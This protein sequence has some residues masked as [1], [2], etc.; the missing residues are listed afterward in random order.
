[1]P[2]PNGSSFGIGFRSTEEAKLGLGFLL[3]VFCGLALWLDL[4]V[5]I[6]FIV[7]TLF[8]SGHEGTHHIRKDVQSR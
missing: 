7:S 3:V 8:D 4:F 1:M 6:T 2:N 5:F